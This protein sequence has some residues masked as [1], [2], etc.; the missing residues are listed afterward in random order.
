[1]RALQRQQKEE[2]QR[3]VE[4]ILLLSER[5]SAR[6]DAIVDDC[7][8]ALFT[9]AKH[10]EFTLQALRKAAAS[11]V[12]E[13]EVPVRVVSDSGLEK[14]VVVRLDNT[15]DTVVQAVLTAMDLPSNVEKTRLVWEQVDLILMVQLRAETTLS[16][17]GVPVSGITV[18]LRAIMRGG[19]K[20]KNSTH[21]GDNNSSSSSGSTSND[22]P[23]NAQPAAA[24][25][26]SSS[27]TTNANPIA[28]NNNT[29]SVPSSG[30]VAQ[31]SLGQQAG[32][33]SNNNNSSSSRNRMVAYVPNPRA[34]FPGARRMLV[35]P[36]WA[37]YAPQAAALAIEAASAERVLLAGD[38]VDMSFFTNAMVDYTTMQ[39]V[40][41]TLLRAID[42][43]HFHRQTGP[44]LSTAQSRVTVLSSG[45]G[46]LLH[47]TMPDQAATRPGVRVVLH[48]GHVGTHNGGHFVAATVRVNETTHAMT[49]M[50][51]YDNVATSSTFLLRHEL[52]QPDNS[53]GLTVAL[54]RL[55]DGAL[56]G[57]RD[58]LIVQGQLQQVAPVR[59]PQLPTQYSVATD[60]NYCN[61][62]S[63][64]QIVRQYA[65]HTGRSMP[66]VVDQLLDALS[67]RREE[68]RAVA[69]LLLGVA[70]QD[71]ANTGVALPAREALNFVSNQ[72]DWPVSGNLLMLMGADPATGTANGQLPSGDLGLWTAS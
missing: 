13:S 51:L 44:L 3:T 16:E 65:L 69:A 35:L 32:N 22:L 26:Q 20:N 6:R 47:D 37:S 36:R 66:P 52:L 71:Q 9:L 28:G 49:S 23:A 10:L 54:S 39:I 11:R 24:T 41:R 48:Q 14:T 55:E 58:R 53:G 27:A 30:A 64:V 19:T 18:Q 67:S 40:L 68:A 50:Q 38:A 7:E 42:E 17:L 5:E 15:L 62:M 25:A 4:H 56:L 46:E 72:H 1:H 2:R 63:M 33:N 34:M 45:Y 70:A 59:A 12:A 43:H 29:R 31:Q 21:G 61:F 60:S 57:S 8:A